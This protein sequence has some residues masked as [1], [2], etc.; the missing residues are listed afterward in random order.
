MSERE[1]LG[2]LDPTPCNDTILADLAASA[3]Q[4]SHPI[5]PYPVFYTTG[6]CNGGGVSGENFPKVSLPVNC[7]SNPGESI[8]PS[9][10]CLKIIPNTS[11]NLNDVVNPYFV[12]YLPSDK[13]CTN[14]FG[15]GQKF[16]YGLTTSGSEKI[17][18]LGMI[19][20][21]FGIWKSIDNGSDWSEFDIRKDGSLTVHYN[22]RGL[23]YGKNVWVGVGLI[24]TSNSGDTYDTL[25]YKENNLSASDWTFVNP[26]GSD[27]GGNDVLFSEYHGIFIAVGSIGN[28]GS[29]IIYSE[30]G[31]N[32]FPP[33]YTNSNRLNVGLKIA[34]NL[35][36]HVFMIVGT[37]HIGNS[38]VATSSDAKTWT[39]ISDSE[40]Q[41]P[42]A[43]SVAGFGNT[44][45]AIDNSSKVYRSVDTGVNWKLV[46]TFKDTLTLI[47]IAVD[48][49]DVWVIKTNIDIRYIQNNSGIGWN[50]SNGTQMTSNFY[51]LDYISLNSTSGAFF[52][53][54]K[55]DSSEGVYE[56]TFGIQWT[57]RCY[58]SN[59]FEN[60]AKLYSWFVPPQY[61]MIFF[62]E[63][64]SLV[65]A[66]EQYQ[67]G[68][69]LEQEPNTLIVN[70]CLSKLSLA[71]GSYFLKYKQPNSTDIINECDLGQG[72]NDG[73]TAPYFLIVEQENYTN[74]IVE[75]CTSNRNVFIGTND[76]Q[77][78]WKPQA[79]GCDNFITSLCK[80]SSLEDTDYNDICACFTQ[81]QALDSE[82]G[83]DQNVPVCCFGKDSSGDINKSCAF[84]Q[85]AYKTSTMLSNCCS[86]A[87]CEQLGGSTGSAAVCQG[88]F[89]DFPV[90]PTSNSTSI[91]NELIN[92]TTTETEEYIPNWVWLTFII[93]SICLFV[94]MISLS[95]I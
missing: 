28:S 64:P 76:L 73:H 1:F 13:T 68:N 88:S 19:T 80:Y 24:I 70:S 47:N 93:S 83:T 95:F 17:N 56:S 51:C 20:D 94:Y 59:I 50:V 72:L 89:V 41:L 55:F 8:D 49:N 60:G 67:S 26:F 14:N 21:N 63:D 4:T 46:T 32:W 42:A 90:A 66:I 84:N 6:Q 52:A 54:L 29:A 3:Q 7:S 12:N 87:E 31:K 62:T 2:L 57:Q 18:V 44:W 85:N 77:T 10:N 16:A 27:I 30:D 86:F 25:T 37:N 61:K 48:K 34:Y 36:T 5:S 71:N 35:Q 40:S 9:D 22:G 81:Q 39:V 53:N 15:Q 45:L 79:S 11:L 43:I 91:N 82:Y 38:T 92:D 65:P 23:A 33:T 58:T 75:M 69:V 74:M 78:V